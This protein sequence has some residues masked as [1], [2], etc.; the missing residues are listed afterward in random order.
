[1]SKHTH[2][3]VKDEQTSFP[4]VETNT[5]SRSTHTLSLSPRVFFPS[6]L[7]TEVRSSS[8]VSSS[9]AGRTAASLEAQKQL[10][11]RTLA[12]N[13]NSQ[14]L[15]DSSFSGVRS[16][17]CTLCLCCPALAL[18]NK[19]FPVESLLR[20]HGFPRTCAL[21]ETP[22]A[23]PQ[24]LRRP[25]DRAVPHI[26]SLKTNRAWPEEPSAAAGNTITRVLQTLSHR[27]AAKLPRASHI[28]QRPPL[29]LAFNFLKKERKV[30]VRSTSCHKS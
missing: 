13:E 15:A 11:P 19:A 20:P 21:E 23:E 9:A 8:T 14:L 30:N 27:R 3:Q 6:A 5:R 29:I 1:M 28:L 24:R 18:H 4:P 16:R 2:S 22:G 7:S 10:F 17:P 25:H 12:E 26:K